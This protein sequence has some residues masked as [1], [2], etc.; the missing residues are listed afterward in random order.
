MNNR[1]RMA[2]I[3]AIVLA[4]GF[5]FLYNNTIIYWDAY[6]YEVILSDVSE[7]ELTIEITNSDMLRYPEVAS[8]LETAYVD[9]WEMITFDDGDAMNQFD[10]LIESKGGTMDSGYV[11]LVLDEEIYNVMYTTYGGMEDEPIYMMLTGVFMLIASG[12]VIHEL[13]INYMGRGR[14]DTTL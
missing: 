1:K 9:G 6:G 11:F 3:V 2:I 5:N 8:T 10:E 4:I 12:L 7:P 13:I 14:K